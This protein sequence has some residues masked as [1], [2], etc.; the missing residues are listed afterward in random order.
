MVVLWCWNEYGDEMIV[1]V[2][3]REVGNGEYL[4]GSA[5]WQLLIVVVVD[6]VISL[7]LPQDFHHFGPKTT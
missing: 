2:E 5:T 7:P 3:K 6:K 1:R 4:R